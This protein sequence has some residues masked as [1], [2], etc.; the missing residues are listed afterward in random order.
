MAEES[1][2][3][4]EREAL[5][6]A[7]RRALER[8]DAGDEDER[9]AAYAEAL[10]SFTAARALDPTSMDAALG[11]GQ[12]QLML[13]RFDQARSS[14]ER[15]CRLD[16]AS[17][18]AHWGLASSLVALSRRLETAGAVG[19]DELDRLRERAVVHL[20]RVTAWAPGFATA[21]RALGE[22]LA[23]L[24]DE[25]LD[26]ALAA[27]PAVTEL[28]LVQARHLRDRGSPDALSAST[29]AYELAARDGSS[30][31]I[32][33]AGTMA[34]VL[35]LDSQQDPVQALQWFQKVIALAEVGGPDPDLARFVAVA[36]FSAAISHAR[37]REW[38]AVK[39][40]LG[41]V[42]SE[43]TPLAM[44]AITF[45]IYVR[46]MLGR[47]GEAWKLLRRAQRLAEDLIAG[48]QSLTDRDFAKSYGDVLRRGG[49]TSEAIKVY[50]DA[51]AAHPDADD[52][53]FELIVAHLEQR[54]ADVTPPYAA[55][56][57]YQEDRYSRQMRREACLGQAKYEFDQ[58]RKRH[59]EALTKIR[60]AKNL[61]GLGGLY[62]LL[63]D[64]DAAKRKLKEAVGLSRGPGNFDSEREFAH[65]YLAIVH[66]RGGDHE[67]A[68]REYEAAASYE[69]DDLSYTLGCATS[70]FRLGQHDEAEA[71]Y[72]AIL[73]VAPGNVEAHVGLAAVLAGQTEEELPD[74]NLKVIKELEEAIRLS[75]QP[76]RR[77]TMLT[78]AALAGL[79]YQVGRTY[80]CLY[81]DEVRSRRVPLDSAHSTYL[82]CA[83][84]SFVAAT[85]LDP[86][87]ADAAA[88]LE[89]T[90]NVKRRYSKGREQVAPWILI[91]ACL[92]PFVVI[93]LGFLWPW[94]QDQL[95][96]GLG[97][98]LGA[99][100]YT[101]VAFGSIVLLIAAISLPQL[102]K[103][104]VGG[105]SLEKAPIEPKAPIDL[106]VAKPPLPDLTRLKPPGHLGIEWPTDKPPSKKAPG[107]DETGAKAHSGKPKADAF[108]G[109]EDIERRAAE[110]TGEDGGS[111]AP[112]DDG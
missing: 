109:S 59:E 91:G 5:M 48:G 8:A 65:A 78:N 83:I 79:H 92:V 16:E 39:V 27:H 12:V 25:R 111:A 71:L 103:L 85:R 107:A 34:G 49:R 76:E 24:G 102:L 23:A 98:D 4:P 86:D 84:E 54:E 73:A 7:A 3:G 52:L 96:P 80:T 58:A 43:T 105:V 63:G 95:P 90:R 106:L 33:E 19:E 89:K 110:Q 67:G 94:W 37:L 41:I 40:Q 38:E 74:R 14:F 44:V 31:E 77:S 13:G 53:R 42:A 36:R 20:E 30:I 57:P 51:V 18:D 70:R 28:W 35:L 81:D 93:H 87:R 88:A 75:S 26:E 64:D 97:R 62:V 45:A 46:S 32:A 99:T 21:W 1:T 55:G 68:L 61:V 66:V 112:E 82:S 6:A 60:A 22:M 50:Q 10:R 15:A 69:P 11:V 29:R 9:T 2:N 108:R 101:G 104:N 56:T 17:A 72:R 100:G 47:Y